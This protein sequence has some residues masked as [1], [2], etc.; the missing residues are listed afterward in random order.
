[1]FLGLG[2]VDTGGQLRLEI[3]FKSF[4]S[5]Q[6]PCENQGPLKGTTS[7]IPPL[8]ILGFKSAWMELLQRTSVHSVVCLVTQNQTKPKP[9]TKQKQKTQKQ[10]PKLSSSIHTIYHPHS[11]SWAMSF[12][13][14][15]VSNLHWKSTREICMG[16]CPVLCSDP[17]I[18]GLYLYKNHSVVIT[19]HPKH[20][21]K[22]DEMF[23]STR[24]SSRILVLPIPFPSI[25]ILEICCLYLHKVTGIFI[26]ILF[27]LCAS[28]G[29]LVSLLC[30]SS[31]P[32][33]RRLLV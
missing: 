28:F 22:L 6:T 19:A 13:H 30:V 2:L 10:N 16:L 8:H 24:L 3:H 26:R 18:Q 12:S 4:T 25:Y 17:L 32:S 11:H 9:T 27:S 21:L 33:M 15:S 23:P 1:M 14:W 5:G 31:S 20:D 29:E 7:H